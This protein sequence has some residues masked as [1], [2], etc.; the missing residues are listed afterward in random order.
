MQN[1]DDLLP[2]LGVYV[3]MPLLNNKLCAQLLKHIFTL[4]TFE[5][6]FGINMEKNNFIPSRCFNFV[7]KK[8]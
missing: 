1:L 6:V 7:E 5:N 4:L 3:G 2:S 8:T